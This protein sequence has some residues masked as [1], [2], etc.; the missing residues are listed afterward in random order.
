MNLICLVSLLISGYSWS[1]TDI[2]K[3]PRG[4]NESELFNQTLSSFEKLDVIKLL[5]KIKYNIINGDLDAARVQLSK[6]DI[7]VNFTRA[8]QLRYLIL[9]EFID[10]N[11]Y[12]TIELINQNKSVLYENMGKTCIMHTISL[13]ITKQ[14]LKAKQIWNPCK[15]I[16]LSHSKT[17]LF[18]LDTIVNLKTAKD[19]VSINK[20]FREN[21]VDT[22]TKDNL[23]LILKL[24]LYL[25]KQ[26]IIIPRFQYFSSDVIQNPEYR[27][28]IGMNYYRNSELV[29]AY[30]LLENLDTPNAEIFKGNLQLLQKNYDAAYAQYKLA[31]QTKNNSTSALE[32][33]IPLAWR[34]NQWED[35]ITYID[36]YNFSKKE[37]LYKLGLLAVFNT[38][39]NNN[40]KVEE[41]LKNITNLLKDAD[42]TEISQIRS[43]NEMFKGDTFNAEISSEKACL[44]KDAM[45]CWFLFFLSNWD[46][47]A[48]VVKRE[49]ELHKD[50]SFMS[51]MTENLYKN[52]LKEEIFVNQKDI[53]ELDN[54][55]INLLADEPQG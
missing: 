13:L 1:R 31:I 20:F 55:I 50:M 39:N 25:N 35:G 33:L 32:R 48:D 49:T 43:Y 47:A 45:N 41:T 10:G 22:L 15:E 44:K 17:N 36:R 2:V 3:Y 4:E 9:I 30:Q 23:R 6:R 5:Q 46:E 18:W 28:L 51:L 12:K 11:Y 8:T 24:A 38:M 26:D 7:N 37:Q 14:D 34:L 54:N 16:L 52:P 29:K 40:Q 27:E 19:F 53:E 21:Y 42:T